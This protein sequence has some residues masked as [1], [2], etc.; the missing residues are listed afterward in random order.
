MFLHRGRQQACRTPSPSPIPRNERHGYSPGIPSDSPVHEGD[1]Q[2]LSVARSSDFDRCAPYLS[3]A[4]IPTCD[5]N[6]VGVHIGQR[7]YAN[8][9]VPDAHQHHNRPRDA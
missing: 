2:A 8:K 1:T 3:G 5:S 4:P 9:E 7:G 6:G